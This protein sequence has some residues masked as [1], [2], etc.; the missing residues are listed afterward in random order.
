MSERVMPSSRE[1]V[2]DA[3]TLREAAVW[4]MRL[5]TGAPD[6]RTR[7]AWQR[8]R[9][10]SPACEMAWQRAEQ[11]QLRFGSLPP[12]IAKP[13]LDKAQLLQA[14][15]RRG[16]LKVL[17]ALL[18]APP[19]SYTAW[20]QAP[21]WSADYR[22]AKGQWR[23]HE[24]PDGSRVVLDTASAI[25]VAF[26]PQQRRIVFK[27]GAIL[28]ETARQPIG[29]QRPFIVQTAH[30]E[31]RA[32]GTRFSVRQQRDHIEVAVDDGAVEITPALAPRLVRVLP[33]GHRTAFSATDMQSFS[34]LEGEIATW[35]SGVLQ[36]RDMPLDEFLTELA[37]YRP[38]VLRYSP[39]VGR[40]RISGTFQL[41]DTDHVLALLRESLPIRV[42]FASRYWVVVEPA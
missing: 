20:R 1:P 9:A 14:K 6:E 41:R 22:T 7:R 2:P 27:A 33:A 24:L 25:D 36:A 8:W 16:A 13:T 42:Q 32:L 18:I 10:R 30:G 12:E 28:V 21:L 3:R 34:V 5:N 17:A 39:E 15:S 38:G 11:L 35:A 31:L 40:L 19:L 26:S 23:A 29:P 4:L 37:R